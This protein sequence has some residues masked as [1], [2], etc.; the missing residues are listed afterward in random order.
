MAKTLYQILGIKTTATVD[1]VRAAYT[2]LAER[3]PPLDPVQRMATKEAFGTLV[4]AQR[5][6]AYDAAL[7]GAAL[8]EIAVADAEPVRALNKPLWAG[9]ALLLAAGTWWAL[10]PSKALPAPSAK[11]AWVQAGTDAAG[12]ASPAAL[13]GRA[14]SAE[15]LFARTAPSVVRVNALAASGESLAFGSGVVVE[16]ATVVTN[17]HVARRGPTLKVKHLAEQFDATIT[18]A[19]ESH[20]LCKLSVPG[21]SAPAVHVGRVANLRVGQKV[22]AIGSPQGL[23]LTLSDGMVSS[24]REGPDGTFVQTTAP[25]SP[26]SSGGGLFDETG[27]LVGIVTFQMRAGQNLNFAVPADWIANMANTSPR[28]PDREATPSIQPP[29]PL[30]PQ[31][32]PQVQPQAD[33]APSLLVGRWV[34]YGPLTGR[35]MELLL[36]ANGSVGGSGDGKPIRGRYALQNRQLNLDGELFLIEELTTDR[37]VLSQGQGRRLVC[38]H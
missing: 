22:Y 21:L 36:D 35:G 34:C 25:I 24:L 9:L 33:G 19:D 30:T 2:L 12:Q 7:E 37:M 17:C 15:D 20:D 29:P 23:D 31:P 32:Q 1:E 10:R 26:G 27:R 14:L 28:S 4:N 11:V 16:G 13:P 38:N 6:A 5:R 8:R 3:V 18:T